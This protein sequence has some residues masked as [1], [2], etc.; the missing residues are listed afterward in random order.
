[1]TDPDRYRLLGTYQTPRCR[2][3][4]RLACEVRGPV[5]VVDLRDAPI[6]WPVC[7]GLGRSSGRTSLAVMGDLALAVRRKSAQAVAHWWGVSVVTVAKWQRLLGVPQTNPGTLRLRREYAREPGVRGGLLKAQAKAQDPVRCAKIAA[8]SRGKP[9]PPGV[10]EALHKGNRGRKA[11]EQTRRR[12]SEAHRKRGTRPPAAGRAWE[13]WED[14]L[15]GVVS[16]AEVARRT[17]R[18]V[19]AAYRR[20]RRLNVCPSG[21]R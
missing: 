10:M 21:D 8:A 6:P 17:G 2:R 13:P 20:R 14:A 5:V 11:G 15:L 16:D 9:R 19:W 1:M 12:M 7:C 4:Q 18:T 3:G